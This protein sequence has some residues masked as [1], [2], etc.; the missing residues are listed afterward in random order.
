[1]QAVSHFL[2]GVHHWQEAGLVVGGLAQAHGDDEMVGAD[3]DLR[4]VA[5]QESF[6]SR[7]EP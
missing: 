6:A 4:V 7:H 2:R 3:R 1:M 5:L